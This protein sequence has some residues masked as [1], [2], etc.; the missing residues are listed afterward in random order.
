M[1]NLYLHIGTAKT[2]TTSI[3]QFLLQNREKFLDQFN[4]LTPKTGQ[5]PREGSHHPLA[6]SFVDKQQ[7]NAFHNAKSPRQYAR[8]MRRE[9][10]GKRADVLLTSECFWFSRLGLP[11]F[12]A[13]VFPDYQVK[14]LMYAR[15]IDQYVEAAWSQHVKGRIYTDSFETFVQGFRYFNYTWPKYW[16]TALGLDNSSVIVAPYESCQFYHNTLLDDFVFRVLGEQIPE[17]F[18]LPEEFANP[19]LSRDALEYMLAVN[20]SARAS[21]KKDAFREGLI[22]FSQH[23]DASATRAFQGHGL[24]SR[25]QRVELLESAKPDDARLAK[26][27]LGREDG[28]LFYQPLDES[29]GEETSYPGLSVDTAVEIS[30][31]ILGKPFSKLSLNSDL[32]QPDQVAAIVD[33]TSEAM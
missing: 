29:P 26:E 13:E 27:Y 14:I 4:L 8:K 5:D 3:Q 32:S 31:H 25:P 22:A 19:R 11:Q 21:T 30:E 9:L 6:F 18:Q 1:P 7:R 28:R 20:R 15:Q 2:G 16:Q 23:K 17:D 12:I 10:K 33:Q 24:L